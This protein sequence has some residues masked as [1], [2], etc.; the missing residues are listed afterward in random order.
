VESKIEGLIE[1]LRE[2]EGR[3]LEICRSGK[4]TMRR[5]HHVSSVVRAMG[6]VEGDAA[7]IEEVSE[8]DAVAGEAE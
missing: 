7:E 8:A 6:V 1:V 5:G 4:M 3:I 2:D